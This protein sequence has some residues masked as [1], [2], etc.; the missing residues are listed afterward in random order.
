[1]LGWCSKAVRLPPLVGFLAAGFLI[2]LDGTVSG[3]MRQT[4]SDVGMTLLLSL[5]GLK[6]HVRILARPQ[7]RAGASLH[8]SIVV[9]VLR[10]AIHALAFL[11][12]S[13][14]ADIDYC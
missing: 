11:G 1:M 2:N 6:L 12:K 7:V 10:T 14:L 9:L 8:M 4:W 13:F 3:E 5:A